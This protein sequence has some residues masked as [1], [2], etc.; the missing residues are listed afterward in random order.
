VVSLHVPGG[1]ETRHL[2][3]AAAI[4]RMR[5]DAVLINAAR[6]DVVDEDALIAALAERQIAAAGLDV[7]AREPA[8]SPALVALDNVVLLPHLG[9]AT[10][11][12]RE[13]MGM[14][15]LANLEAWFDGR[16]PPDRIA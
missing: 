3:D 11:E 13:A 4:A 9:S 6:G 10:V 8:V 2:I 7:Y 12:A 14:R 16:P 5:P 15:A 1:A